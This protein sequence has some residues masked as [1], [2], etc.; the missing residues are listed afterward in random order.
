MVAEIS[1][2]ILHSNAN[3]I[4]CI[5]TMAA[6]KEANLNTEEAINFIFAD[7]DSDFESNSEEE[8]ESEKVLIM[9]KIHLMKITMTMKY[10]HLSPMQEE[11]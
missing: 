6:S 4:S 2:F 5:E 10:K 8:K 3:N 7:E 9:A 1:S 11:E